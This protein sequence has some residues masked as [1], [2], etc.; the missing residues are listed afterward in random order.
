MA[1]MTLTSN[2]QLTALEFGAGFSSPAVSFGCCCF[3]VRSVGS[4]IAAVSVL[5][6]RC[7][8]CFCVLFRCL[9]CWLGVSVAALE[10]VVFLLFDL[11]VRCVC[12]CISVGIPLVGVSVCRF[13]VW[14]VG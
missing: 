1:D 5:V 14:S 8:A 13:V 11:L 7:L 3:I 4:I 2:D 12:C 9:A 10:L 6:F